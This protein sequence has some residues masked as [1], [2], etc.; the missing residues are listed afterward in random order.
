MKWSLP[1]NQGNRKTQ[2]GVVA[3]LA[4]LLLAF[5]TT[6]RAEPYASFGVGSTVVRGEAPMVDLTITYPEAGPKDADYA[7]GVSF[8]GGS[9]FNGNQPNQF[10]WRAEVL[11]GF[12][13]FDVGLG[14]AYLQNTDAFNGSHTNFTLSL[15]YRWEKWKVSIRHY[16]NGGTIKPNKGRDM[17]YFSRVF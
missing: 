3:V 17:L 12:G 4:L 14:V 10:A 1:F 7:I 2:I 15:H 9:E 6:A 11:D 8:I 5:C 16:S 13:K